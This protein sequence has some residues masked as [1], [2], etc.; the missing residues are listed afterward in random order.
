MRAKGKKPIKKGCPGR[1]PE[2]KRTLIRYHN[3]PARQL[4][5][6]Q[7]SKIIYFHPKEPNQKRNDFRFRHFQSKNVYFNNFFKE[8]WHENANRITK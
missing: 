2:T 5:K 1:Q 7:H 4:K 8:M 3:F 6:K